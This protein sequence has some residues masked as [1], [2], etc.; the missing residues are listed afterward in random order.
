MHSDNI[1]RFNAIVAHISDMLYA[2]FPI[3][4]ALRADDYYGPEIIHRIRAP[5][6]DTESP[7][8]KARLDRKYPSV[9]ALLSSLEYYVTSSA[10]NKADFVAAFRKIAESMDTDDPAIAR[11]R[12][13]TPNIER[14][15]AWQDALELIRRDWERFEEVF[16]ATRDFLVREQYIAEVTPAAFCFTDKGISAMFSRP[17]ALGGRRLID[18]IREALR[19]RS[20]ED[21][22]AVTTA[23]LNAGGLLS[24]IG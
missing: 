5:F 13:A 9:S 21:L 3:P 23:F 19:V 18:R 17:R 11:W 20:P 8:L 7:L 16:D 6:S 4:C 12:G 14:E 15:A 2:A 22:A 10:K 24:R 1:S